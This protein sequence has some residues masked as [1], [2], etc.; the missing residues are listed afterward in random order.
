MPKKEEEALKKVADS[1]ASRGQLNKD[2]GESIEEAKDRF[3]YGIMRK[4]GWKPKR[5]REGA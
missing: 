4:R 1:L 3:V 5:E 2:V